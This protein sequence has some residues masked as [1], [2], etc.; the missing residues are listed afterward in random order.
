[1]GACI[2]LK[3]TVCFIF[4]FFRNWIYALEKKQ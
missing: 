1:L 2:F 4:K 3:Y